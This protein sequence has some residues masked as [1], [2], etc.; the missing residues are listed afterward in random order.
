MSMSL[1]SL[2]LAAKVFLLYLLMH[3]DSGVMICLWLFDF[4]IYYCSFWSSLRFKC[5]YRD[6]TICPHHFRGILLQR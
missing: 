6:K 2:N 5:D 3:Q 4:G 1:E